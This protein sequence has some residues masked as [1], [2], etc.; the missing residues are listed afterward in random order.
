MI[1]LGI[2]RG[3]LGVERG[4]LGIERGDLGVESSNVAAAGNDL[5]R[6]NVEERENLRLGFLAHKITSER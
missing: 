3:D 5:D 4:D 6:N 2:E 1:N